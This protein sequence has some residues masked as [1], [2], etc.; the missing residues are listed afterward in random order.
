LLSALTP[1]LGKKEKNA[2]FPTHT[3]SLFYQLIL[4]ILRYE[5]N[6]D[7]SEMA[8]KND[9]KNPSSINPDIMLLKKIDPSSNGYI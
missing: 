7:Y 2:S 8:K 5:P 4:L 6:H 3:I 1:E 9:D